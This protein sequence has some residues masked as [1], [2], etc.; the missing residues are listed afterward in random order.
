[1][2]LLDRLIT[3]LLDGP[4]SAL[5]DG[6]LAAAV[7]TRVDAAVDERVEALKLDALYR[8][9]WHGDASRL[10][11]H[12]TA[13]VNNALFNVSGGTITVGKDAFFGHDVAILTGTHDIEK[14]GRERQLAFPRS[15]RDVVIGEGVWLASHV[16][17][18]GPLTIGEH[19]VV[20]GGSLVRED[21]APYTVV[22]GRPAKVVKT[23]TRPEGAPP[24]R[25]ETP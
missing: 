8:H 1:M 9:R 13:I 2:R 6:P 15:G 7:A 11:I 21:V 10:R 3:R 22:A 12:E 17:V 24:E 18:L 23:I 20:A 4:L 25:V 5:L 14:F 16:L 19:A